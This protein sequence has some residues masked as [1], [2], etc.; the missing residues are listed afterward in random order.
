MNKCIFTVTVV[1]VLATCSAWLVGDEWVIDPNATSTYTI[2]PVPPTH[3][4]PVH[5]GLG[6]SPDA[7]IVYTSGFLKINGTRFCSKCVYDYLEA[8]LNANL[9]KLTKIKGESK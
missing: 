1:V 6:G 3:N 8:Y 9:P 7:S 2:V 5:G 4:C